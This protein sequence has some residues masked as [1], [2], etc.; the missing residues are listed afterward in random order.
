MKKAAELLS[1]FVVLLGLAVGAGPSYRSDA[2]PDG[3]PVFLVGDSTM[4]SMAYAD[5]GL[6]PND[7]RNIVAAAF[8]LTFDARS[9]RRVL[10]PGGGSASAVQTPTRLVD[11]RN[12]LGGRR[13][14]PV[15]ELP[16]TV[17]GHG[18]AATVSVT[19]VNPAKVGY[20]AVHPCGAPPGS[21]TLNYLAGSVVANT[22]TVGLDGLGRLCVSTLAATDLVVD[23][24]ARS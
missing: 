8:Q 2:M 23:L 21:S 10:V 12:G 5:G 19:A 3:T 14:R 22:A 20:L 11:T 4:L 7:A 17:S 24:L 6:H 16:V 1:S 15:S 9:C 18:T 13:L